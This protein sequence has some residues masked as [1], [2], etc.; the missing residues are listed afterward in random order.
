MEPVP[1]PAA[2]QTHPAAGSPAAPAPPDQFVRCRIA[3]AFT[4]ADRSRMLEQLGSARAATITASFRPAPPASSPDS[5]VHPAVPALYG[6]AAAEWLRSEVSAA[7]VGTQLV[8]AGPETDVLAARTDALAYGMVSAE[9][10]LL[11][12]SDPAR[13]VYCPHC[14]TITRTVLEPG[15]RLC[16][17]GCGRSLEIFDHFSRTLSAYLGVAA[18][19]EPVSQQEGPT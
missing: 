7:V 15:S 13:R 17:S 3:L 1:L 4:D 19:I 12:R 14:R 8:L 2:G 11:S 18:G 10:L 6:A 9:I 16:C 5:G